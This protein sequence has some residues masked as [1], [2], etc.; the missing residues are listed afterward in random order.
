MLKLHNFRPKKLVKNAKKS[1]RKRRLLKKKK[2]ASKKPK[3]RR[4][5]LL[6][7]MSSKDQN[8]VHPF[9]LGI[10]GVRIKK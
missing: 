9:F 7:S 6:H 2:N 10:S 8:K 4:L 5:L 3:E 1:K